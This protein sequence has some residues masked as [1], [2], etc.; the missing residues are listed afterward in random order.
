M[1][2]EA[3]L[4]LT[5]PCPPYVRWMGYLYQIIAMRGRHLR[6]RESW[7]PHLERTR[8]FILSSAERCANRKRVV[9]LGSGLL[10]D[11]PLKQLSGMF[12]EVVLADIVHLPEVHRIIWP[13][14]N[15]HLVQCD[16][17]GI[18]DKLYQNVRQN[19][20]ELPSGEPFFPEIDENAGLL[21]SL[22]LV[23][24]LAA[25]PFDYVL[26]KMPELEGEGL[27]AW[28]DEV[29]EAHVRAL[30]QLSC[31]VCLVADYGYVWRDSGGKVIEEGSTIGSIIL[32][33]PDQS[34]TWH[35]APLGE[36]SKEWAK[37]LT[38][39]AWHFSPK[40]PEAGPSAD[41]SIF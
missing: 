22:N 31:D 10:L 4:W 21:I 7:R 6:H 27:N 2:H 16:V 25:V 34:W 1:L 29:R 5:T 30:R 3:Y 8:Q 13:Y 9:V 17:T 14:P 37:E 11:F 24:Q 18:A 38:V 28:S 33:E 26:R 12:E 36:I 19:K 23:S 15:V 35:L 40:A 39:G 20:R 41:Q 32:P